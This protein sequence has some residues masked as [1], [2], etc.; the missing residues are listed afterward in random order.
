[1]MHR[2]CNKQQGLLFTFNHHT[3]DNLRD[4]YSPAVVTP[5]IAVSD[6]NAHAHHHHQGPVSDQWWDTR[7]LPPVQVTP[8]L[9]ALVVCGGGGKEP[10]EIDW[11]SAKWNGH[12]DKMFFSLAPN[13]A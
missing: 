12:W 7:A 5:P 1:M 6:D 3:T 13:T 2:T 11:S 4:H 8:V 10:P 9:R